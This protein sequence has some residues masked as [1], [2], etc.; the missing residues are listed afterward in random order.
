MAFGFARRRRDELEVIS[1]SHSSL[2]DADLLARFV[3]VEA[4]EGD[5]ETNRSQLH[6]I[7]CTCHLHGI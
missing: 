5:D 1:G 2:P 4:E 7:G 3:Y 6:G